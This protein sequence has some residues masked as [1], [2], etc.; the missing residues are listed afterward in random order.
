MPTRTFLP[1]YRQQLEGLLWSLWSELG[2]PGWERHHQECWIDP[3]ALLLFTATIEPIDPRL[4]EQAI[5]WC[6]GYQRYLS[7]T[8]IKSQLRVYQPDGETSQYQPQLTRFLATLPAGRSLNLD[9]SIQ[10][11]PFDERQSLEPKVLNR[12]ALLSL[13]LRS[14]LGVTAKAE[15]LRIFFAQ[16]DESSLTAADLVNEGIGYTKRAVRDALEDLRAG[17]FVAVEISGNANKYRFLAEHTFGGFFGLG[18]LRFPR[19][20]PL[21]AV[22]R[23]I[24]DLTET[25]DNFRPATRPIEI[26]RALLALRPEISRAGLQTPSV[27]PG[28]EGVEQLVTWVG[29][30]LDALM[31]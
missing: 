9:S 10:P 25:I 16:P 21:F 5:A 29:R 26:R 3:D 28:P 11:Y 17:G 27:E 22:L 18:P 1:E 15:I 31:E 13:R 24:L 8:R 7:T 23:G 12:P 19:W 4:R 14:L 30:L 6:H 2:V 20:Q